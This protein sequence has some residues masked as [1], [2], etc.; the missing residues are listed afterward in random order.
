M[1]QFELPSGNQVEVD[2]LLFEFVKDE[3]VPGTPWDC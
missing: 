2:D 1:A 3:V